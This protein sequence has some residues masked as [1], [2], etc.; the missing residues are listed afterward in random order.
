[1]T[2]KRL[3]GLVAN[4]FASE[5]DQIPVS[6]IVQKAFEVVEGDLVPASLCHDEQ[7]GKQ[8]HQDGSHVGTERHAP[9][10]EDRG[11]YTGQMLSKDLQLAEGQTF[12]LQIKGIQRRGPSSLVIRGD[13]GNSWAF[14]IAG[15]LSE[16]FQPSFLLSTFPHQIAVRIEHD[17]RAKCTSFR[18]PWEEWCFQEQ[19]QHFE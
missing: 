1:M 6:L 2:E 4:L 9:A 19:D 16:G 15:T 13:H 14:S 12:T 7:D 5:G 3:Q 8:W 10:T 11:K 17:H 18:F